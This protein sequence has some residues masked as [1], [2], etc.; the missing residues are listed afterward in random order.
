M[1]D[2]LQFFDLTFIVLI[3]MSCAAFFKVIHIKTRK[4]LFTS[5]IG[6][7]IGFFYYQYCDCGIT[8]IK[9]LS[10][11][12]LATSIYDIVIKEMLN[13]IKTKLSTESQNT[14]KI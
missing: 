12:G 1:T 8:W 3:L 14:N 9:L 5:I 11:F 6:A 13:F 2:I 7:V 4:P 10:S